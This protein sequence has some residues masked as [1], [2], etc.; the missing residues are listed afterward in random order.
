M[1]EG[2]GFEPP[3]ASGRR[4]YS[5]VRLTALLPLREDP[6]AGSRVPVPGGPVN[7]RTN[8]RHRLV[9]QWPESN[10]QPSAY[11][12][13]ALPLELHWLRRRGTAARARARP[14]YTGEHRPRQGREAWRLSRPDARARGLG[15]R[16]A[17]PQVTAR[18]GECVTRG[19]R[20]RGA[21]SSRLGVQGE[22]PHLTLPWAVELA[23]VDSLPGPENESPRGDGEHERR[24]EEGRAEVGP[25]VALGMAERKIRNK[26]RK[27]GLH[28]GPYVR[29][30]GLIY[31]QCS[32][33]MGTEEE[34]SAVGQPQ[35]R[36]GRCDERCDVENLLA[37]SAVNGDLD[38][39]SPPAHRRVPFSSSR[40][41][42]GSCTP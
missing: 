10:G 11:K 30:S 40:S 20:R 37:S 3:K 29:V 41:R 38:A 32:G 35:R 27:P 9:S 28:V 22:G 17:R 34:D 7:R 23:E 2:E 31:R 4:V 21:R 14:D 39:P 8:N 1:V 24:P 26:V 12:A 19:A 36:E 25:G 15:A 5:P 33:G 18:W 16:R 13:D 6:F 42:A